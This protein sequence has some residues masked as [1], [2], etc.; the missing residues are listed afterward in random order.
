MNDLQVDLDLRYTY[1]SVCYY[2]TV[3]L[4]RIDGAVGAK[5]SGNSRITLSVTLSIRIIIPHQNRKTDLFL[6][7]E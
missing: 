3:Y 1:G 5:D 7:D 4:Q 2:P 6:Q